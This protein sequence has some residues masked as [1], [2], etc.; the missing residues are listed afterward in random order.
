MRIRNVIL[1]MAV[2][3]LLSIAANA[4]PT[5]PANLITGPDE[6]GGGDASAGVLD[7]A[8]AGNTTAMTINS[9][10]IS[11]RW[12]GYY[13]N[14]SGTI[15]LDDAQ[16][17]TLYSWDLINSQGEVYAVN[18]SATP[19]WTQLRCL[20]FSDPAENVSVADINSAIGANSGDSD[21]VNATF[22]LTFDGS[23]TIGSSVTIDSVGTMN[24]SRVSLNVNDVYDTASFDEVVLIDNGTAESVV[25]A[26]ILEEST[27]GFQ[28]V[29]LDFQMIVG[30]DGDI[31]AAT[32]YYFYVE[33]S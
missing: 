23:F 1:T 7:Q 8:Q 14:I 5:G 30:E 4:Q 2:F 22:N 3:V 27:A 18:N 17:N 21:T 31:T 13:G 10:T 33:L 12:Q 6:R 19:A 24:C 9:T 11:S 32:N 29:A 26:T 16:N 20:N 28:N 25:Y 15:T